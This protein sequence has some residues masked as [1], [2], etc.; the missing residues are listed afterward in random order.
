MEQFLTRAEQLY[1]DNR[2]EEAL[3]VYEDAIR[4]GAPNPDPRLYYG[5]GLVLERLAQQAYALA[6]QQGYSAGD[7]DAS[8]VSAQASPQPQNTSIPSE[9][10]VS[11]SLSSLS[12]LSED[13]PDTMNLTALAERCTQEINKYNH[14]EPFD[15]R[16]WLEL[17]KRATIQQDANA[18]EL[19]YTLFSETVRVWFRRHPWR[20]LAL[21]FDYE[22]VYIAEAFSHF[23][24][25]T[26]KQSIKFT[27]LAV[28]LS[29]LHTCLNRVIL[30]RLRESSSHIEPLPN[31]DQ[32]DWPELQVEDVYNEGKVWEA[33]EALLLD[34]K[35]KR[36]AYLHFY[37]NLKSRE[38]M[39]FCPG[40]FS[41][42]KEIYRLKRNIIDR[43]VSNT[44]GLLQK[45]KEL[46]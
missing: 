29:Y 5:R 20:E 36:L 21:R 13:I 17:I 1:Q 43:L 18:W 8:A 14:K 12:S 35:E 46:S 7:Q 9:S 38:I 6:K 11:K 32:Q 40:E 10:V 42:V 22:E 41:S 33:I 24:R 26:V 2:Y 25:A 23:W 39:Q 15:N 4:L 19:L 44:D 45:L 31:S 30:D 27:S 28:A 37:C 16:Y 34:E 3:A